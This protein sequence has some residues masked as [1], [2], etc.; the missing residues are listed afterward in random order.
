M[1]RPLLIAGLLILCGLGAELLTAYSET[2]GDIGGI[3]FSLV[4]FAGLYGAP[5]LLARDLA[6]RLGWRWPSLL[7]L[8][9][10]LGTAQAC[11]IDQS[12][13]SEDYQG[14][15]GWEATRQAT[16]IPGVGFSAVNAYNFIT[17]HV[18]FSFGAPVAVTEAWSP[19]R[20]RT[21]WLGPIGTVIAA[22]AYLGT[23]VVILSDPE[24][25]SADGPQLIGSALVL[26]AFVLAAVLI[27]RRRVNGSATRSAGDGRRVPLWATL[28]ITLAV[29]LLTG[30]QDENWTG[31]AVGLGALM[32][33][34]VGLALISARSEWTIRHCAAVGLGFLLSRGVLA[35]TYFPLA[36]DVAPI[37]KY[38]H[39]VAMLII[40]LIAGWLALRPPRLP[41]SADPT[42]PGQRPRLRG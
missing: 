25:R 9:A 36:G 35:F 1:P 31:L 23:A 28:L 5:A 14:Y 21:P 20:A 22:L 3:A 11:L 42:S 41:A 32:I 19:A 29:A 6:R 17:G 10:A 12:L 39:N 34:A 30:M 15:E 16:L 37:P 13:F 8:F 38:S 33:F 18:I 2:T 7:L 40:V 26:S 27:G 4:F 24:S